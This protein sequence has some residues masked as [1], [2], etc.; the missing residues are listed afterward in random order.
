MSDRSLLAGGPAIWNGRVLTPSVMPGAT[1]A[2]SPIHE[3]PKA[4]ERTH[5]L[6]MT[7]AKHLKVLFTA[8]QG[9]GRTPSW[10]KWGLSSV[11]STCTRS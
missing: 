3:V 1:Q 5:V 9:P 2:V 4:E 6:G 8:A 11:C 10:M 7:Q